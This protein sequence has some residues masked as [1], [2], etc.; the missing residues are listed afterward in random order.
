MKREMTI[1]ELKKELAELTTKKKCIEE[2][3]EK[4]KQDVEERRMAQLALDKEKRKKEMDEAYDNYCTL[5]NAYIRDYGNYSVTTTNST[6]TNDSLN[7]PWA[8]WL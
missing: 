7:N 3:I 6:Y 4:K 2:Q 5:V 8:W 1:E